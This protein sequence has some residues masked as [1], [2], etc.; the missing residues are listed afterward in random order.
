MPD[1]VQVSYAHPSGLW[2]AGCNRIVA[3]YDRG[4]YTGSDVAGIASMRRRSIATD[5][6]AAGALEYALLCAFLVISLIA[7]ASLFGNSLTAFF[8]QMSTKIGTFTA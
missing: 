1:E 4:R 7:G 8:S 2:T 5:E 3:N 6:R